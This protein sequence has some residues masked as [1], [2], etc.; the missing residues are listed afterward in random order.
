MSTQHLPNLE[1]R[2]LTP[3][4]LAARWRMKV[5]SLANMRARGDGPRYVKLGNKAVRYRWSDI[6]AYEIGTAPAEAA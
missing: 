6:A 1:D 3:A 2:L 4:E 5:T